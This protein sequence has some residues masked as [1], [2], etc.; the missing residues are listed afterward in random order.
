MMSD[1]TRFRN[2]A[3]RLLLELLYSEAPW[4]ERGGGVV[5]YP[6]TK[7]ANDIKLRPIKQQEC[8]MWLKER[9][10]L[11]SLSIGRTTATVAINNPLGFKAIGEAL[12]PP[13]HAP[14]MS[15]NPWT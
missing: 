8:L 1:N 4:I 9:G 5:K 11:S 3:G 15:G 12:D 10:F 13:E 14:A 6:F 2:N 7:F